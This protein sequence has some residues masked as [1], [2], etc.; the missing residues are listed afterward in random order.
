[1]TNRK[2]K[3]LDNQGRHFGTQTN[4]GRRLT[5]DAGAIG[6]A[7]VTALVRELWTIQQA[8]RQV[9]NYH[10]LAHDDYERVDQAVGRVL[11][12]LSALT[13]RELT[14]EP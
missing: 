10:A 13:G 3:A 7:A 9:A 12:V 5:L 2:R 4:S 8:A 14:L 1:M 6:Q 11:A